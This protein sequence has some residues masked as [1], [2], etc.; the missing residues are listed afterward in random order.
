MRNHLLESP[1]LELPVPIIVE[2]EGLKEAVGLRVKEVEDFI[3]HAKGLYL[4][5]LICVFS[6][7]ILPVVISFSSNHSEAKTKANRTLHPRP[8]SFRVHGTE[9]YLTL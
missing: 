8:E 6:R 3:Q 5:I 1:L 9:F 7:C 4:E 2:G